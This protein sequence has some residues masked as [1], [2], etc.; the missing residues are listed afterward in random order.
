M[1]AAAIRL[2]AIVA[3]CC[4]SFSIGPTC[5]GALLK[6]SINV[7]GRVIVVIAGPVGCCG[8]A[9]GVSCCW[10]EAC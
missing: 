9:A 10:N 6:R 4:A 5:G 2:A 8:N 1:P 3:R 7:P